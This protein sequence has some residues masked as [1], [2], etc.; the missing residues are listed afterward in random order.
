MSA[1]IIVDPPKGSVTVTG[2]RTDL[3]RD[4]DLRAELLS[5]RRDKVTARR[6]YIYDRHGEPLGIVTF[7][8]GNFDPRTGRRRR[9]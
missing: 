3:V 7:E 8:P 2:R 4:R 1:D 9:G 6:R 5:C